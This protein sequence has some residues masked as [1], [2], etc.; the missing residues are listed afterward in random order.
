MV[1]SFLSNIRRSW[2]VSRAEWG[3][4]NIPRFQDEKMAEHD[5]SRIHHNRRHQLRRFRVYEC[6]VILKIDKIS[7]TK[8]KNDKAKFK[9]DFK[10]RVYWFALDI[11]KFIDDLP[12]DM[13]LSTG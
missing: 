8:M 6:I 2:I 7:N 4:V 3:L 1:E 9:N 5:D 10:K 13:N 11:I 12:R